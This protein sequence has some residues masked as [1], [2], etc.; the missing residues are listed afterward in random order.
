MMQDLDFA[1]IVDLIC[2]EDARFDRRAYHFVRQGLDATVRQLKKNDPARAQR[3]PHV[4]GRELLEGLRLH[5][6]DQFGP[7]SKTVL[8]SWGIHRCTDFG[9]I[10]FNLIDY[11]V[12]SKTEADRREDF[13]DIYD[14]D[15]AFVKPFQPAGRKRS[16]PHTE[17]VDC[18]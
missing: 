2:R 8:N 10:V 18:K 4:S 3:S 14:F 17:A 15:G 12:F 6:L 16:G 1:E 13:V 11:N 7:M 5:A 9:E